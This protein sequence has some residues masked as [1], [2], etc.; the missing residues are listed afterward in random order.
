MPT[1]FPPE[2]P[3]RPDAPLL[4]FGPSFSEEIARSLIAAIWIADAENL[5]ETEVRV[6]AALTM[7][8]GFHPRD[9]LECMMAAQAVASHFSIMDLHRRIG[10]PNTAEPIAIKLRGNIGQMS[11]TFSATYHDMERRQA[12]PLPERP[13]SP[14]PA[15]GAPPDSPPPQSPPHSPLGGAPSPDPSPDPTGDPARTDPCSASATDLK[16]L[17]EMTE[18]PED[19]KTRPDGTPGSLAAYAPQPPPPE[20]YV[21]QEPTIMWA[22]ATRPKPWR[23]VNA[24]KA[25][26]GE[27]NATPMTTPLTP[28][29]PEMQPSRPI[30]DGPLGPREAMFGGDALARFASARFDADA[31]VEPLNFDDEYS[32]V[33]L[34]LISTGG[35]PDAEADRRAMMAA[36]PEG[37]AIKTIRYGRGLPPDKPSED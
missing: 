17:N 21:P 3:D 26:P 28:D 4:S 7:L 29:I 2:Y 20:E 35:D 22:L 18:P 10:D 25:Q 9:H 12:K 16:P 32:E 5:E 36:H 37:K 33:D 19:L 34:E 8:E 11:R 13:P 14:P 15:S 30:G 31:P 1:L 6:A 27:E 23:M 24:P